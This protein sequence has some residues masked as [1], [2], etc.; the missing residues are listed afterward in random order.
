MLESL[1]K[2]IRV[3][4]AYA[5]GMNHGAGTIHLMHAS[6]ACSLHARSTTELKLG[7]RAAGG[8]AQVRGRPR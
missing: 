4:C 3:G 7:V 8:L 5:H 6:T 2:V 1:V